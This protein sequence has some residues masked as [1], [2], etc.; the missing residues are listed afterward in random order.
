[1]KKPERLKKGDKIAIVSLSSGMI[2][3]KEFYHKYL[4]GKQRLEEVFG[5]EV[6]AMPH[7]LK[8]LEFV[9]NNP[10]LRAKD[11]MDAFSDKSIKGIICSIG[12]Y[13]TLL[14]EP[15]IDYEILSANP[16]VFMGFSDTTANHFM[17]HKAGLVSYYGPSLMTDFAEYVAMY[18]YTVEAVKSVL[19]HPHENYEMKASPIWS[20][21]FIP[22]AE[23]NLNKRRQFKDDHKG[24]EV[25]Q[26]KGIVKG[27]LLGGCIDAFPIYSGTSVWPSL[28]DWKDKLLFIETSEEMPSP[29]LLLFYLCNLGYQGILNAVNGVLVG[30]PMNEKYYEEYKDV[31]LKV[32]RKFKVENLPILYNVNFGHAIPIGILPLGT[33]VAVDFD[34]K[35]I[36]FTEFTVK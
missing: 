5:F 21:E 7:A 26:G 30:K 22:W 16:K 3:E 2:G 27:H 12:G 14:I 36:H 25:L 4:L 35:T 17:M 11:L 33:E 9:E 10:E 20:D 31:I 8:G 13:D 18:D 32:M 6:V 24:Y 23:E 34:K 1:M 29:D 15:F 28:S 19:M